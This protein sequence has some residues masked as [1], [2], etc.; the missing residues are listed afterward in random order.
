L[1]GTGGAAFITI[2]ILVSIVGSINGN[3]LTSPRLYFAQARDGLFFARFATI[4]PRFKTPSFSI[5]AQ[6]VWASL[7]ALSG[8]YEAIITYAI[9]CAWLFY[10]LVVIGLMILRWKAPGLSRP[11][12]IWGYPTTPLVFAGVT[13][14][15]L[16]NALIANP[17]PSLC[18]VAFLVAGLPAYF[19]WRKQT[20]HRDRSPAKASE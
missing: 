15:F 8:S 2:A 1:F 9:F 10:L 14:W 18:G 12:R 7:L 20:R 3:V 13:V 16:L 4:H 6:G 11:Y 17:I 5:L 19:L